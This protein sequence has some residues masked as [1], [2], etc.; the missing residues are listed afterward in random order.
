MSMTRP[1]CGNSVRQNERVGDL[2]LGGRGG[3]SGHPYIQIPHCHV[4]T[5][6]G[7]FGASSGY[8]DFYL[9]GQL[10]DNEGVSAQSKILGFPGN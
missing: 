7:P 8:I 1:L 6:F 2:F 10:C 3:G 9:H 5:N 4:E